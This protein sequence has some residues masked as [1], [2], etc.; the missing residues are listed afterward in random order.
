MDQLETQPVDEDEIPK[1][2]D[3]D[4]IPGKILALIQLSFKPRYSSVGTCYSSC[5]LGPALMSKHCKGKPVAL[6]QLPPLRALLPPLTMKPRNR[7]LLRMMRHL[8]ILF[9]SKNDCIADILHCIQCLTSHP[10]IYLAYLWAHH[11][12]KVK[13]TKM[14]K[15]TQRRKRLDGMGKINTKVLY[16]FGIL[17]AWVH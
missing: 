13:K 12:R 4:M 17:V 15:A 2:D 10:W 8:L 6:L 9:F 5:I 14:T 1:L 16:G 3:N 7:N 11:R